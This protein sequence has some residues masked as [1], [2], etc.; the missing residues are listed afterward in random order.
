MDLEE[1]MSRIDTLGNLALHASYANKSDQD[2]SFEYK[3]TAL[4]GK[5][6]L[7]AK[8]GKKG[9]KKKPSVLVSHAQGICSQD[10]WT[11]KE[12][13]ERTT[14]LLDYALDHWSI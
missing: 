14:E 13:D 11:A 4:S 7:T 3:K 1:L 5:L 12:I 9:K 6:A 10:K 8:K 2:A